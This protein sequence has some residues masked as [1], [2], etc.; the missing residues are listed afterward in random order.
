[1]IKVASSLGHL[2]ELSEEKA[3]Y[4]SY[5]GNCK[6]NSIMTYMNLFSNYA[7]YIPTYKTAIDRVAKNNLTTVC[8]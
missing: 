8:V 4:H 3:W 2:H 5:L 7:N 6:V 1:M